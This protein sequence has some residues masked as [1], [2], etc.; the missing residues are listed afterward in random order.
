VR[1]DS[2]VD[3]DTQTMIQINCEVMATEYFNVKREALWGDFTVKRGAKPPGICNSLCVLRAKAAIESLR[4]L[5][6][7]STKKV[8]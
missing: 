1:L 5:K 3:D 4:F 6:P 8:M 2:Y 7:I